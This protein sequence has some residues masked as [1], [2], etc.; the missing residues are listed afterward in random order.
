MRFRHVFYLF[1]MGLLAVGGL[2]ALVA[3]LIDAII[4]EKPVG[5]S[6]SHALGCLGHRQADLGRS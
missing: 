6:D 4:R 1:N 3:L 2:A 5:Y